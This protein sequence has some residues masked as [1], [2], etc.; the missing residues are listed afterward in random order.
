MNVFYQSRDLDRKEKAAV[1]FNPSQNLK[2]CSGQ[3][4]IVS[5]V[6]KYEDENKKGDVVT[7]MAFLTD[8]GDVITTTSETVMRSFERMVDGL[9]IDLAEENIPIKIVEGVSKNGR[10]YYDVQYD[11][12]IG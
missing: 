6:V 8:D 11:G 5:A 10:T 9:E 7:L 3:S 2:D 4:I 1:F 12:N